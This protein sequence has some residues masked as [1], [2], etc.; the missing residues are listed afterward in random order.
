MLSKQINFKTYASHKVLNYLTRLANTPL[1]CRVAFFV[2]V[3]SYLNAVLSV[4][5][6][7]VG[8]VIL[9]IDRS[10]RKTI[11]SDTINIITS[12]FIL[13]TLAVGLIYG[14]IVGTAACLFFACLF[15]IMASLRAVITRRY[16]EDLITCHLVYSVFAVAV[17][18]IEKIVVSE[19][20]LYR[21]SST[22]LN[23]LYYSY[24]VALAAV[25]ATYRLVVST[26][27]KLA[28]TLVLLAN[29]LGMFLSGG[30]LPWMGMFIGCLAVLILCKRYKLTLAFLA[31]ISIMVA[32]AALFPDVELFAALRLSS[33]DTGYNMRFPYW[34]RAIECFEQSPVA[35]QG[36]LAVLNSSIGEN[37][38][39]FLKFFKIFDL[40][41]F[42]S[43]L[44]SHGW[45]LHSHN[46][47]FELISSFGILGSL[48][49]L[50][51]IIRYLSKMYRDFDHNSSQ[52]MIALMVGF[53][54][55]LCICSIL[56]CYY[57]GAQTSVFTMVLFSATGLKKE[58]EYDELK[59][60]ITVND[61]KRLFK[62]TLQR[63]V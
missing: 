53:I 40:S 12:F 50:F 39:L 11:F 54:C 13:M 38:E 24:F 49:L 42:F 2:L 43:D 10:Q 45:M 41:E 61:I 26:R 59:A 34:K 18:V 3:S 21:T 32:V 56:D 14:N 4:L 16:F 9:F 30:R 6:A 7:I 48:M 51:C 5:A 44:K 33:I 28:H 60:D 37:S 17:A 58:K 20:A 15:I 1:A 31:I 57:I 25:M 52:P 36:F 35:G 19:D 46:I 22:F 23:P 55:T 8:A 62:K 63:K 29:I 47:L 27:A